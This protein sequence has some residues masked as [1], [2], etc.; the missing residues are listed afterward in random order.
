MAKRIALF[1]HKGGVSK[2]TTTFH[3]SWMLA[4]KG[5]R[6]LMVDADSQCN[7]T[8][9]ILGEKF[10]Q[11]Y[12]EKNPNNLKDAVNFAFKARPRIIEAVECQP[13]KEREGLF[14]LPGHLNLSEYEITLGLAQSL[15]NAI[16]TLQNI[17]GAFSYLFEET[18]KKYNIDYIL[19]DLNPSLGAINQNLVMTSDYFLIPTSADFFSVMALES[20]ATVLPQWY[21]LSKK[22]MS[23]EILTEDATYPLPKVIPKFLG[24]LIQERGTFP[25]KTTE[26]WFDN[27][28]GYV[29]NKFVPMLTSSE[30]ILNEKSY[31][32]IIKKDTSIK[33]FLGGIPNYHSLGSL[34]QEQRLPVFELSSNTEYKIQP[35]QTEKFE[36]IY[37]DLAE[38]IIELTSNGTDA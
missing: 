14:L 15:S 38:Q 20:M 36:I 1:N 8:G 16:Y 5:Y 6:V 31:Q 22:A 30:M 32:K 28:N 13:I 24:V 33:Y 23:M 27:I 29:S 35:H 17:P 34:Y 9:L 10:E 21:H 12:E 7:L 2:T 11:F 3:L 19:I 37:S 26:K 4:Q 18:A 25:N